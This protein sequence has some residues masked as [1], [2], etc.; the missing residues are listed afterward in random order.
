MMTRTV[1]LSGS[2]IP[3]RK[4]K[5]TYASQLKKQSK[6]L[7]SL[8]Q[9]SS[10]LGILV[11]PGINSKLTKTLVSLSKQSVKPT[12]VIL[13]DIELPKKL[14]ELNLS[15]ALLKTSSRTELKQALENMPY[16]LINAGD[17]LTQ[18]HELNK[19]MMA[20]KSD[21]QFVYS[22]TDYYNN[23]GERL[24]PQY[25]PNW[26]PD[27]QLSAGYINTGVMVSSGKQAKMLINLN[28]ESY[29]ITSMIRAFYLSKLNQTNLDYKVDHVPSV[30][31]SQ[32]QKQRGVLHNIKNESKLFDVKQSSNGAHLL[33]D[34]SSLPLVSLII[35]T[36]NGKDLVRMCVE[37]IV[38][39][40]TYTN[41]EI[42]LVDNNSDDVEAIEY[43]KDLDKNGVVKLLSY[44]HEFNYSA[45][46]NFAAKQAKGEIIGLVNNDIEVIQGMWLEYMV[47]HAL[48]T[49]VGVVGAKLLY[50]NNTLQ[51]AGVV[52][53]YGGGQVMPT[54]TLI[55]PT[56]VI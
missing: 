42:L 19:F 31:I 10:E 3:W 16:L 22:D 52:M 43:F 29:N 49:D 12:K 33:W 11:F 36:K 24:E 1:G 56:L 20:V 4:Q 26:S 53:G 48:R 14:A 17:T 34:S 5:S 13:V 41:Y 27:Y 21:A 39:K 32:P 28:K 37:S 2:L 55:N 15:Y 40:T 38:E 9:T 6:E 7:T 44:P 8:D 47:G 30:L 54:N 35:P 18:G 46:N 25:K 50:P 51:H 23:S 45:I